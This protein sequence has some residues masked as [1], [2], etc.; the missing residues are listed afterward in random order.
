MYLMYKDTKLI[1]FDFDESVIEVLN[2]DRL[3]YYLR[4]A[5]KSNSSVKNIVY[6]IQRLKDYLSSRV[7]SLSKDNAKKIFTLFSI[8]QVDTIE[9]RVQTCIKCKGISIQDSFWIKYNNESKKWADV[10][11]RKHK[12]REIV[13]ISLNGEEPSIT[14]NPICPELT[15][16]GLFRKAWI[17]D[18]DTKDL[19]LI[20]SDRNNDFVNTKMEVLASEI[21][22]CTNYDNFVKYTGRYRN[23]KSGKLYVDK[24][25]SFIEDETLYFT[26]AWEVKDYCE[27]HGQDFEKYVLNKFGSKFANI[28]VIDFILINTDRHTQNYG[29]MCNSTDIV[30]LAPLF[31]FNLSLVADYFD[32][33]AEDTL[34]QTF[35][36][37]ESIA[38]TALRYVSYSDLKLDMD[39]LNK[40]SKKRKEYKF[41]IDNVINRYNKIMQYK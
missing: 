22:E 30:K 39:K 31:D 32:K 8:P 21:L 3:P 36:K 11:I 1:Y 10:N 17:R 16:K 13:D 40:L 38:N 18:Y 4:D 15:S 5:F 25:K 7:L 19:Y 9:N 12:L 27:R 2:N 33:F 14:V 24:C 37:R 6:N 20:K 35:N 29:F 26:E 41:I 23:T 34:S 28:P